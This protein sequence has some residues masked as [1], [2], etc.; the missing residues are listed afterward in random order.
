MK[1]RQGI[2]W[3]AFLTVIMAGTATAQQAE[4]PPDIL[5]RV[6]PVGMTGS[7]MEVER[8]ILPSEHG[9]RVKTVTTPSVLRTSASPF[10]AIY[11]SKQG[12]ILVERLQ[13]TQDGF[14]LTG[15]A[16]G[17]TVVVGTNVIEGMPDFV[18]ALHWESMKL[19]KPQVEVSELR[20]RWE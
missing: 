12:E 5:I 4:E 14:V 2:L 20:S 9:L 1:R 3:I 7:E 13:E 15:S 19:P 8:L 16:K 11:A 18:S 17:L 6:K 10:L